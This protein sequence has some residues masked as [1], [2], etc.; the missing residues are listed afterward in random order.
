[1]NIY[2]HLPAHKKH[3]V[4]WAAAALAGLLALAGTGVAQA[5]LRIDFEQAIF[6][7][8][9]LAPG[10]F[11]ILRVDGV[12]HI[13][14]HAVPEGLPPIP[15]TVNA[16]YH[17]TSMDLVRWTQVT[18]VLERGPAVWEGR[19]IWAPD[20]IWDPL[21]AEWRMF[22]TAADSFWVQRPCVASSPDLMTWRKDAANPL[23][24]P[25][26]LRYYWAPTLMWSAFRDPFL[27]NSDGTWQMLSTAASREGGYPGTKRGIVHRLVSDDLENWTD[28]GPFW[29]NDGSESWHVLE[30]TQYVVRGGWHHLFVT[31]QDGVGI[32]HMA[33]DTTGAWTTADRVI[34]DPGFASEIDEFDPGT[35]IFSRY[36]VGQHR[37]GTL[38]Y[39]VRLDTLLWR[40]DG[41]VP[42]IWKPHPLDKDFASR[43]GPATLGQPTWGDNPL[44]RGEPSSGLVGHGWFSS[45]E[46]YQG[47]GSSRG[48]PG[49]RLGDAATGN[50]DSY[51][52]FIEGDFIRLRVGG[53]HYPQTCYV[54]LMDAAADTVLARE[55]G[56]GEPTMTERRW[57]VRG[58]RGR[59]AYI[60]IVDA[61]TDSLGF[62][63]VDE[64]EEYYDPAASADPRPPI[65]TAG[66]TADGP[67]PNPFNAAT[68]IRFS[69][70]EAACVEAAIY[71]IRGRVVWR[72]TAVPFA[73]GDHSITWRGCDSQGRLVESGLYL[74]RLR[75]VDAGWI[76]GRVVLAK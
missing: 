52:F 58:W 20:V 28:A 57:N 64:I 18:P 2:N 30:S 49:T 5:L 4:R 40:E 73:P 62:I 60:R 71:D 70:R 24:E 72:M 23:F 74:Y 47:P 69:L 9:G 22:Y 37:D 34:L 32:S 48:S 13:F 67:A 66:L 25:D 68:A 55:T 17:A 41:R 16:I 11:C 21:H 36:L 46:Y 44:E 8:A 42:E 63:S 27:F 12:Y 59:R 61:E 31:E 45:Q 1:M 76:A 39:V 51:P 14:F 15:H 19:G 54:A 26:T 50:C 3:A 43:T 75:I 7:P 29:A 65:A 6:S 35:D 38:F 56:T 53:G 33:A 10:D